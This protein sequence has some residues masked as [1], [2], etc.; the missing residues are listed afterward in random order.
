MVMMVSHHDG[1]IGMADLALSRSRRIEIKELASQI[2]ASQSRENDQMRRWYRQWYGTDLPRWGPGVGW[3]WHH[4]GMMGGLGMPG[5]GSWRG[6]NLAALRQ[7]ADFDRVFLEQMIPHHQQAELPSRPAG[8]P[9]TAAS[10]PL[11]LWCC[12]SA[13]GAYGG[14]LIRKLPRITIG[15]RGSS[16]AGRQP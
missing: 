8:K 16:I 9:A 13:I 5:M 11:V 6:T 1:A 2:K 10:P 3:G 15:W 4:D 12:R 14:G 7:A